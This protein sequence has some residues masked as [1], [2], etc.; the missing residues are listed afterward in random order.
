LELIQN[1]PA[2]NKIFAETN[3]FG[4]QIKNF[5]GELEYMFSY[6][7]FDGKSLTGSFVIKTNFTA[8]FM[9]GIIE[10]IHLIFRLDK[11]FVP[12]DIT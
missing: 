4:Q 9:Q 7:N 5:L 1:I 10:F 8:S 12:P 3:E 2:L 6:S 11:Y